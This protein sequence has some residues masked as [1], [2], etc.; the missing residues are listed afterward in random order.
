MDCL[1]NL[2]RAIIPF[3]VIILVC[4]TKNGVTQPNWTLDPANFE[5][6]M[7]LTGIGIIE[8]KEIMDT[9]DMVAAFID[10]DVRGVQFFD[11]INQGR[12]Y[13]YMVIY[14]SLFAGNTIRFKM[15]DASEDSIIDVEPSLVFTENANIGND[16][17]PF[18]FETKPDSINL[19]ANASQIYHLLVPGD[20]V[21]NFSTYN[22][23][24]DSLEAEY[25]FINDALGKDNPYFSLRSSFLVLE[26][27]IDKSVGESFAVHV[28]S[29]TKKDCQASA[30]FLLRVS[31]VVSTKHEMKDE[32]VFLFP[33]PTNGILSFY[34]TTPFDKI[35]VIDPIGNKPIGVSLDHNNSLDLSTLRNQVYYINFLFGKKW[36]AKKM[37]LLR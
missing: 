8:C 30:S 29:R 34:S 12:N 27:P 37:I 17:L 18:I 23:L 31:D 7:T 28:R 21:L 14:D 3:F 26:K 6:T 36:V 33:N 20:T 5:Y 1:A 22:N 2:N 24:K 19:V 4:L 16:S 32:E 13:A 11:G 9:N 25:E 15:Y 10:G 35:E